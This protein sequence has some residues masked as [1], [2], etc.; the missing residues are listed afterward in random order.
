MDVN[1]TTLTT[2]QRNLRTKNIDQISTAEILKIIND[3]DQ[4]VAGA[5]QKV[6]PHIEGAVETIYRCLKNGGRLFYIGAGT[7][8]RLGVIDAAEC[9]PTFSTPPELVEAIIAG[10]E[11]AIQVAVEGAEDDPEQGANDLKQRDLSSLDVVV[12]IAASGRTPYVIG[13]LSY[14]NKLGAA[15]VALSCNSNAV[16]SR[17]AD[18]RIEVIVGPEILTGSTRMKA[19]TAHKMV[20]NM[21]TTTTMIKLGKIYE[22]LMVDVHASN[23]KLIER[24]R[25][26]VMTITDVT[27][28]EA[29]LVLEKANQEVKSAIVMIETGVSFEMAKESIE[30][31]DGFVRNAIEIANNASL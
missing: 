16:I 22:N 28:D 27:Y 26:I 30:K 10:G 11:Q 17:Y 31:A 5:I 13:A 21:I 24:S 2:E 4:T 9:P 14:A 23:Q 25:H 20:L 8:G 6:L 15:T 12:G 19:A 3:E 18:H 29:A 7:S 1:L